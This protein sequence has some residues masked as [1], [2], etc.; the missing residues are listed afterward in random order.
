MTSFQTTWSARYRAFSN[1]MLFQGRARGASRLQTGTSSRETHEPTRISNSIAFPSNG[2]AAV[3]SWRRKLAA[4][5]L[6]RCGPLVGARALAAIFSTPDSGPLGR[7]ICKLRGTF[8]A[9]R[10]LLLRT[11][12]HDANQSASR[13][14]HTFSLAP[15]LCSAVAHEKQ[16]GRRNGQ[17]VGAVRQGKVRE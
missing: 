9:F 15:V 17:D 3:S 16:H 14:F 2:I 8:Q 4:R 11:L 13:V 1:G 10:S 6:E 7:L 5:T 12:V